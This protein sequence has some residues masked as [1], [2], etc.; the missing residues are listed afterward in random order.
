MLEKIGA[1]CLKR[2]VS[3]SLLTLA[4]SFYLSWHLGAKN[5]IGLAIF[6]GTI[7][8]ATLGS[9]FMAFVEESS[10]RN[11]FQ[12]IGLMCLSSKEKQL[13]KQFTLHTEEFLTKEESKQNDIVWAFVSSIFRLKQN[14]SA[15]CR[16]KA[17][18]HALFTKNFG[19][20]NQYRELLIPIYQKHFKQFLILPKVIIQV[21]HSNLDHEKHAFEA[22][23][24]IHQKTFTSEEIEYLNYHIQKMIFIDY[25]NLLKKEEIFSVLSK[26]NQEKIL[27]ELKNKNKNKKNTD[28]AYDKLIAIYRKHEQHNPKKKE[29][30]NMNIKDIH[31]SNTIEDRLNELENEF[32]TVFGKKD[33]LFQSIHDLFL[34]REK[35]LVFLRQASFPQFIEDKLFLENDL[36]S[37]IQNFQNEMHIL[38]KMKLTGHNE[39]ETRKSTILNS[40]IER[41]QLMNHKVHYIS[42]QVYGAIDH[43]LELELGVN[44]N[45]L[46]SKM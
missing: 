26:Q 10:P 37:F 1:F 42:T 15:Y 44:S 19:Q 28:D 23:W 40:I 39:F 17:K 5:E 38:Q 13:Q 34:L 41:V 18:S 9:F 30:I 43:E 7:A 27:N 29:S 12:L 11:L 8:F 22:L 2:S 4:S 33:P 32:Y 46:H 3:L 25:F 21:I 14:S 36:P 20:F 35:L 31:I 16:M 6:L 45:V 24:E